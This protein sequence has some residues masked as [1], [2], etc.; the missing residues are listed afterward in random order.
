LSKL[1]GW[2]R[3]LLGAFLALVLPVALVPINLYPIAW[4][5]DHFYIPAIAAIAALASAVTGVILLIRSPL[6]AVLAIIVYIPI[7]GLV[8]L[9]LQL[10][11]GCAIIGPG[12]C[13]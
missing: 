13:L 10:Q 3:S 8:L 6:W 7:L 9:Q 4:L 5:G 11:F 2:R 12:G 1:T